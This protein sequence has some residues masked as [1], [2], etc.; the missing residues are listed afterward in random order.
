MLYNNGKSEKS[1]KT[2]GSIWSYNKLLKKPEKDV[3]KF[4]DIFSVHNRSNLGIESRKLF[5]TS[6][7]LMFL[8]KSG[9]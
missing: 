4:L 5:D 9:I 8:G 1:I 6:N 3:N 7:Y 2:S